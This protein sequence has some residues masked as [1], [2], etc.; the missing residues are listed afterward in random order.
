M[1]RNFLPA[2]Y[3]IFRNQGRIVKHEIKPH[4]VLSKLYKMSQPETLTFPA[5]EVPMLCPPIP[6]TSVEN[7][8]YIITSTDVVR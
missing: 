7:G 2:F 5:S 1:F 8:G 4:P 3:T 6:W